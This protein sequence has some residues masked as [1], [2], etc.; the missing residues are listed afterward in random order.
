MSN[1]DRRFWP[2]RPWSAILSAIAM[3]AVLL[4]ILAALRA[5]IQ[6]PSEKSETV[7]LIGITLFSLLSISPLLEDVII[8]L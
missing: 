4:L 7:V 1:L 6:W 2:F 5:T 8:E 3:L